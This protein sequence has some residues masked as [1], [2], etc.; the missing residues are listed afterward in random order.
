MHVMLSLPTVEG[1]DLR[2]WVPY[3]HSLV[4]SSAHNPHQVTS[5]VFAE[6]LL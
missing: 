2:P 6:Y 1:T 5:A 4:I 3:E